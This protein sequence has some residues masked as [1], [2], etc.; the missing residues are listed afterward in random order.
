MK[1]RFHYHHLSRFL[2][3][4]LIVLC[5]PTQAS[6]AVKLK[7]SSLTLKKGNVYVLRLSGNSKG[8]E[9]TWETSRPKKVEIVSSGHN[10][11]V[12]RAKTTGTAVVSAK[13]GKRTVRC[14]VNVSKRSGIPK[15]LT[16]CKGDK[17][18]FTCSKKAAW[19][20]SAPKKGKLSAASGK[21]V[22]FTA[23]KTGTV[24]VIAT[25]GAKTY[26]CTVKIIRR[27]GATKAD[28][29][30]EQAIREAQNSGT[31]NPDPS[32]DPESSSQI[33][34]TSA[35][36][37]MLVG[38]SYS[39]CTQ[40][41]ETDRLT[42]CNIHNM[43][44]SNEAMAFLLYRYVYMYTGVQDTEADR[45]VTGRD[46]KTISAAFL[47]AFMRHLF[48]EVSYI[49]AWKIFTGKYPSSV[50]GNMYTFDCTGDFGDVGNSYFD[51]PDKVSVNNGMV[52]LSGRVMCWNENAQSYI[53]TYSYNAYWYQRTEKRS[54]QGSDT[55]FQFDHV[56]IV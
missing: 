24:K 50:S 54:G 47:Q 51:S 34:L 10:R 26:S 4:L 2:L 35:Q 6:A 12:L 17:F 28:L 39:A 27:D 8:K 41:L 42:E 52:C 15:S 14:T 9:V 22:R 49:D 33:K 55:W 7:K 32:S 45:S 56:E 3:I 16:L 29:A 36:K 30:E 19:S 11:A 13:V 53:H 23:K 31:E 43:D 37:N 18:T 21:K 38:L 20:L 40:Q 48:G 1:N 46:T 5:V 25:R 44:L